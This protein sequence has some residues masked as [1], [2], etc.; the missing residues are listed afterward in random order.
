MERSAFV[1]QL[2]YFGFQ[3]IIQCRMSDLL[4]RTLKITPCLL[5]YAGL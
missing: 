3:A 5:Q 2:R 1:Q 4:Y